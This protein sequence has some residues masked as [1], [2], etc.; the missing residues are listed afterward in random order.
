MYLFLVRDTGKA[1]F[2]FSQVKMGKK[3][4]RETGGEG[5]F[6]SKLLKGSYKPQRVKKNAKLYIYII[7]IYN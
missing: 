5:N 2:W 4:R 3:K 6:I 7:Y 1:K